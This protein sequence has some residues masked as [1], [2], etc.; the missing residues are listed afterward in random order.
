MLD[1]QGGA[2]PRQEP[3]RRRANPLTIAG[4]RHRVAIRSADRNDFLK[5]TPA[6]LALAATTPAIAWTE[7]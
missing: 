3:H 7:T 2:A 6:A 4:S 5:K 1:G